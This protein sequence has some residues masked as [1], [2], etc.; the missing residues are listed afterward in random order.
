MNKDELRGYFVISVVTMVGI[1]AIA[2]QSWILAAL[3][4]CFLSIMA[5]MYNMFHSGVVQLNQKK[6]IFI[7]VLLNGRKEIRRRKSVKKNSGRTSK[8]S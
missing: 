8:K 4:I 2:I 5:L 7:E 6:D 3:S 1:V